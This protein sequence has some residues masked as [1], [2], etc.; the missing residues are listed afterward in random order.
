MTAKC[1]SG[2]IELSRCGNHSSE[3]ETQTE[4]ETETPA[5]RHANE[6]WRAQ[7]QYPH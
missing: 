7:R 5:E 4:I 2:W 3:T 1:W 6:R